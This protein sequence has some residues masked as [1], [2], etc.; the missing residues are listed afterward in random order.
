MKKTIIAATVILVCMSGWG[1]SN[2]DKM[3][4][5]RQE[6]EKQI[7]SQEKILTSTEKSIS[8]QVSNLNI[9]SA[10]LKERSRL[11]R[12]TQSQI[13]ELT[14]QESALNRQI[15]QLEKEYKSCCDN[16][17]RAC[18]F[19]QTQHRE[20]NALTFL[21]EAE[22]FR[23][24]TRRIRYLNEYSNS[25][26]SLGRQLSERKD[27]LEKRRVE[28][29]ALR[30]EKEKVESAEKKQQADV[31]RE[32]KQQQKVVDNLKSKRTQ[33]KKEIA[34]QQKKMDQLS[35]EIDR[36]IQ[37]ALKESG[38]S[39]A[40]RK[41]TAEDFALSGSFESNKG[42][43]PMPIDG[44]FLVVGK[45]GISQVAG[46]KDVKQNNLGIDI[47]GEKGARALCIFE[48]EVSS[49]FQHGKGQIGVLVR[50]GSYI[51][52]YCNLRDSKLK[53]GDKVKAGSV[54]GTI[55]TSDNGSPILHFQ[56]HKE[57]TRLNPEQ[58]I[59]H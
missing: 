3:R 40:K 7:A 41:M 48:G 5:E 45:Y 55:Q 25:L 58:W 2:L 14:A 30:K 9:I 15:R 11:L 31:E 39:Q 50:H 17:E 54:I 59:K 57:S 8:S 56:L 29:A 35:K 12:N 6:L 53:K 32:Q 36:Q 44:A 23:Q 26:E 16:Y 49:V 38:S 33:L 24:L 43:L 37:L 19:Y 13:R 18:V 20:M 46:Q 28:I 4:S 51:S 22:S 52:V 10:R 21:L 27:T 1:Q 47:Q 42:K 34:A